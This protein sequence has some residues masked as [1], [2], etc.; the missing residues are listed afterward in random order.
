[1][2]EVLLKAKELKDAKAELERARNLKSELDTREEELAKDIEKAESDE[3]LE[4]VRSAVDEIKTQRDANNEDLGKLEQRVAD[5]EKEIA[6]LEKN[7]EPEE[8]PE[9][10]P[11]ED[12]RSNFKMNTR[13][14]FKGMDENAVRAFVERE[15]VKALL[16]TVRTAISE[17]RGITGGELTIPEVVV[18]FI[19]QNIME[20]SKLYKHVYLRQVRGTAR[21]VVEGTFPEAVW[22]DCCANVNELSLDINDAEVSCWNIGGYIPVCK[23]TL[24]D[25][26]VDLAAEII[27]A[28]GASIGLGLDKAIIFG[29]GTRMPMGIFTR[30]AQTAKPADYSAT[31]RTWV[32]LH[33][34]NIKTITTAN[35]TGIKLFE[36]ILIDAAAAKGKYSRGEKVWVMNENTLTALKVAGLSVTAAGAVVT[37]MDGT[38]PVTGGVIEVLDFMPDNM[39]VGGYFD[40]YLLAER[41]GIT[42]EESD[43]VMFLSRKRVYMAN[44]RYDGKPTIAEG[45]VAIGINNVTPSAESVVFPPDT[46]NAEVSA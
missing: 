12:T 3:E 26:D 9:P 45:F 43:H 41:E 23:S 29:L 44:A 21:E 20:Y 40:L 5:I 17:K 10:K 28:L 16:A 31:E 15:D 6:D 22:T 42:F 36:N 18:G 14:A 39:I 8:E 30:L 46:A 1:M 27:T 11:A 2:L 33:T 37:A 7:Q 24:Q 38:M 4:A 25:S 19:R 32:D 35:S 13:K 34:S